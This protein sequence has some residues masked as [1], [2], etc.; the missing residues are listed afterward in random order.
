VAVNDEKPSDDTSII[1]RYRAAAMET[2]PRYLDDAIRESARG[3][4][5]AAGRPRSTWWWGWRLPLVTAAVAIVSASLLTIL[6]EREETQIQPDVPPSTNNSPSA[7]SGMSAP[8][9]ESSL[10]SRPPAP[11]PDEKRSTAPLPAQRTE[12]RPHEGLA[13][14]APPASR[15]QGRPAAD[16]TSGAAQGSQPSDS[17]QDAARERRA[18]TAGQPSSPASRPQGESQARSD[19]ASPPTAA[20]HAPP[21]FARTP[22]SPPAAVQSERRALRDPQTRSSAVSALVIELAGEPPDRW[23]ARIAA[24]RRDGRGEEASALLAEF[25]RRYPH[26]PV[27]QNLSE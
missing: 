21:E 22:R 26:E 1:A 5:P 3:S 23:T 25:R 8:A 9:P 16:M 10:A 27:P 17:K 6:L 4:S 2:P 11:Q 12:S 19:Q 13:V 7:P 24:L 15:P 14:Q 18:T 20:D